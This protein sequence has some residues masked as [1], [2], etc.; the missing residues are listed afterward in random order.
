[1]GP[2]SADGDRTRERRLEPSIRQYPR[3]H[4]KV[5]VPRIT[6]ANTAGLSTIKSGTETYMTLVR[7]RTAAIASHELSRNT[8]C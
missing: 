6:M 3:L 2:T 4:A 1:M 8:L 5:P 7:T